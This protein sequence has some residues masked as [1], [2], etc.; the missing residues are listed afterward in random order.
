MTICR[1]TEGKSN[2][3]ALSGRLESLENCP[4]QPVGFKE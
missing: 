3:V 2:A 1:E 4:T